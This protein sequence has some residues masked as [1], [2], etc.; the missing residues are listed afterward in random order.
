[1]E[2]HRSRKASMFD[3]GGTPIV[4]G[5]NLR[6]LR[7]NGCKKCKGRLRPYEWLY[8]KLVRGARGRKISCKLTFWDFL[9]FTTIKHCHYCRV[10]IE[11]VPFS[12]YGFSGAQSY[13][14]DRKN[15]RLGYTYRNCVVCC[16]RCNM[17]KSSRFSYQE[18]LAV[19]R[20]IHRF[21]K[22]KR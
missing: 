21:V 16:T 3:C 5:H 22:K 15:N 20:T 17:A 12:Q 8:N 9:N 2:I 4:S 11:W 13:N 6:S 1:M 19:G 10:P 14:L 7:S 18:W